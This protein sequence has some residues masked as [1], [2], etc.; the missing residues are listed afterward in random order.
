MRRYINDAAT[1]LFVLGLGAAPACSKQYD[2]AP[3]RERIDR[4]E[5]VLTSAEARATA[6]GKELEALRQIA[7]AI[8]QRNEITAVTEQRD[9]AGRISA[10]VLSFAKGRD[11]S[12]KMGTPGNDAVPPKI[13]MLKD[14][15]GH[16]Y[17]AVDG[18]SLRDASGQR[19]RA[20][21]E[22]GKTPRIK[23]EN[24]DWYASYDDGQ[25]WVLLGRAKGPKGAST[26]GESLFKSIDHTSSP[27]T[28]TFKFA[29]GSPDLIVPRREELRIDFSIPEGTVLTQYGNNHYVIP[30]SITESL[31]GLRLYVTPHLLEY[32]E[33][34]RSGK[35]HVYSGIETPPS[36]DLIAVRGN[37]RYVFNCVLEQGIVRLSSQNLQV[38]ITGLKQSQ[39]DVPL[40]TNVNYRVEIPESDRD[41]LSVADTRAAMRTE[42]LRFT[43]KA[44]ALQSPRRSR[45]RLVDARGKS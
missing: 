12:I 13:S 34:E 15:D 28:V 18:Q 11:V 27:S 16:Y 1:A 5:A 8:K 23:I 2:D 43:A 38:V 19:Y 44:N 39:F 17:W 26:S 4:V 9:G 14:S 32:K 33:G 21:G 7:N 36:I 40:R 10:Y 30:F 35:V 24:D 42:T 20:D 3:L 37:K 31:D 41:W 45:V 29:N 6:L 25:S 22:V